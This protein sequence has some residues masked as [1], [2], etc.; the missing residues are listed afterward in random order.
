MS[1]G[2]RWSYFSENLG[3]NLHAAASYID[4]NHPEWDVVALECIGGSSTVIVY[5]TLQGTVE[6]MIERDARDRR[7]APR[8]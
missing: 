6:D 4:R 3:G 8:K 2:K 5:R 7:R 1:T